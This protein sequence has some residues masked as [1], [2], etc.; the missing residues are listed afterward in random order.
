[1]LSTVNTLFWGRMSDGSAAF[2]GRPRGDIGIA[3]CNPSD[4]A[5]KL[6]ATGR[7]AGKR[8]SP[9]FHASLQ[10]PPSDPHVSESTRLQT[11]IG[12]CNSLNRFN[13]C[14]ET[15]RV[16]KLQLFND[17]FRPPFQRAAT[18][19]A[20]VTRA[21]FSGKKVSRKFPGKLFNVLAIAIRGTGS[22]NRVIRWPTY[23]TLTVKLEKSAFVHLAGVSAS[24]R[25]AS[26]LF[27]FLPPFFSCFFPS[28]F[29]RERAPVR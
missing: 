17:S 6:N 13:F 24:R 25:L 29:P 12:L 21:S 23:R 22:L 4:E 1:M 28:F 11:A 7:R 3:T 15:I 18:N 2:S 8:A 5:L 16:F 26:F 14:P 20:A 27:F 9:F 10:L 19:D